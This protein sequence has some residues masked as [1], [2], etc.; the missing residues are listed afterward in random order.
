[1]ATTT[2]AAPTGVSAAT[3]PAPDFDAIKTR[4]QAAWASGDYAVVGTTLQIVGESLCEALDLSAGSRVLDVAAGN[5][6]ATLAAARRFCHVVS[7]DYVAALLDK[8]R[9][10][11]AAERLAVDFRP[12][13]A[14]QLPF[15]DG[16]FDVALSVFGVM[17][18][19]DQPRAAQE[20]ARV[21]RAGGRIG[22]ASWTPDSFIGQMFKTIAAYVPPAAGLKSP[23]LWGT[24]AHLRE[25]F[26][27]AIG[28]LRATR[29][30]FN[31]RYYSADHFIDV[32][33]NFYGP[34]HKAFL[35]LPEDR[36]PELAEDLRQLIARCARPADS[37]VVPS[38]YLEVVIVRA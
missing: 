22:L 13:D 15:D 9:E 35:A 23:M 38:D 31:F 10:R 1:M 25:L 34:V 21:T 29:R 32:F 14:E 33:R 16:A 20:M 8:G 6:N 30:Q 3:A 18:T 27:A 2:S 4:Q 7:T 17:F 28:E 37:L 5:G 36:R 26:G 12:A 24:E 19:P 11:A